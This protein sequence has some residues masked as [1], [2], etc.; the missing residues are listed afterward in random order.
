MNRNE[1]NRA[2]NILAA[3]FASLGAATLAVALVTGAPPQPLWL[4]A[5]FAAVFVFLEFFAVEVNDRLRVSSSVMVA[6][7]APV[8]FGRGSAVVAVALMA[9]VSPLL[10]ED[11]RQWNWR[12]PA[13]N[14][15]QLVVSAS[16][17]TAVFMLFLPR[18]NL[19][20]GALP[21]I[22]VGA[23]LGA[24]T[25]DWL[26]FQMVALYVRRVYPDRV[27][28]PWSQ[29]MMNHATLALLA[30]LG[31]LL[32]AA[33]LLVGPVILPLIVTTYLVGHF[34]FASFSRKR[35]SH[36]ATIRGFVKAVEALDPYTRGHTERVAHFSRIIGEELGLGAGRLERL[37]WAALIHDVGRLAVP[38]HLLRKEGPLDDEEHETMCRYMAV[39]E[40]LL[41]EVGFLRPMVAV[42]AAAR[43][44]TCPSGSA[45][46]APAEA[47]ILA[48]ADVFDAMTSARSYRTAVTQRQ[49]FAELRARS[50]RFGRDVVEALVTALEHR[51]E[52]YGSPDDESAAAVE[53]LVK[54]RAIR[55]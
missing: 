20:T 2:G 53:R 5:A 19:E 3:G 27:I 8:V 7:T 14:F 44:L 1:R 34:G 41:S 22:V 38:G 49:A 55:A 39:V 36:E 46:N 10:P 32:G 4:W 9:A 51:G 47:H 26:N 43:D 16:A 23:A 15:G 17:G 21:L 24:I 31:A 29:L 6:F 50:D 30:V 12:R 48:A 45:P 37:R 42:A 54:E 33:Y 25:N 28:R 52:L 13:A 40:S 18:G 11:L 35:E